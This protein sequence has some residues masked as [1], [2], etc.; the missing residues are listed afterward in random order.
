MHCDFCTLEHPWFRGFRRNASWIRKWN[1][2]TDS[3]I[4]ENRVLKIEN[5]LLLALQYM[6]SVLEGFLR[7][8]MSYPGLL[9]GND[10]KRNYVTFSVPNHRVF[11]KIIKN[12]EDDE[13]L[14]V[15]VSGKALE[16]RM[17]EV[18]T[19]FERFEIESSPIE[20]HQE[21]RVRLFVPRPSNPRPT[22]SGQ[23]KN[24]VTDRPQEISVR[25]A[26][27][28]YVIHEPSRTKPELQNVSAVVARKHR[29]RTYSIHYDPIDEPKYRQ[30]HHIRRLYTIEE[31]VMEA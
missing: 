21:L 10:P 4:F 5:T 9:P 27:P 18:A 2:G 25:G 20:G 6:E 17:D 14:R 23:G 19:L 15:K 30:Q 8:T 13:H 28:Q 12:L 3:A 26:L 11:R 7:T 24:G 16:K 29:R 1:G 22:F 31:S